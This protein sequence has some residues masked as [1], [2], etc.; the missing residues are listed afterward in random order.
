MADDGHIDFLQNVLVFS[1]FA[2][3]VLAP[4]GGEAPLAR[5]IGKFIGQTGRADVR[6][7]GEINGSVQCQNGEVVI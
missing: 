6:I 7:I 1:V 4:A 5:E 2:E 3:C